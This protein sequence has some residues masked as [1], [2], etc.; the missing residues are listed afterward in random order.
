MKFDIRKSCFAPLKKA[1]YSIRRISDGFYDVEIEKEHVLFTIE[2]EDGYI[3]LS[4]WHDVSEYA[5]DHNGELLEF[6]NALNEDSTFSRFFFAAEE[7]AIWVE[8]S[9]MKPFDE[10]AF[11]SML[12][13]WI[14]ESLKMPL[15]HK[16]AK[17]FIES[18]V[19]STVHGFD[20]GPGWTRCRY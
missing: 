16:G 8:W 7:G 18:V 2:D 15:C 14:R 3:T 20:G 9:F 11:M 17:L 12:V 4:S 6:V 1:G 13:V 19:K 5:G 10:G